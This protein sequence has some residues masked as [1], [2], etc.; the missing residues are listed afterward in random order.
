MSSPEKKITSMQFNYRLG[1]IH[2]IKKNRFLV[3]S[4]VK[5]DLKGRYSGSFMGMFWS[6]INPLSLFCIYTFVFSIIMKAKA[7]LKYELIPFPVWLLAGM[8][9]WIFFSESVL[10]AVTAITGSAQLVKKSVFDKDIL[11]FCAVCANFINH[12]IYLVLFGGVLLLFGVVPSLYVLLLIPLWLIMFL[13][14]LAWSYLLSSLNVYIRDIGHGLSLVLQLAFFSTPIVYSA[15]IVP[16]WARIY[17]G[18]NPY[19]YIVEFYREILLLGRL[20][21]LRSFMI[22]LLLVS[23]FFVISKTVFDR[24]APG[25]ADEL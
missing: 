13:Y 5:R 1:I 23:I 12:L 24:L 9:P 14:A 19:A 4:L 25:F 8:I 21:N 20:P 3:V 11:P 2:S 17:M 16:S 10:Q 15:E 22:L 18:L 6:F 7:G